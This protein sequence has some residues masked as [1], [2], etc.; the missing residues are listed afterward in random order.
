MMYCVKSIGT[1]VIVPEIV[2]MG[3]LFLTKNALDCLWS[4]VILYLIYNNMAMDC[5]L[6]LSSVVKFS[7]P[8]EIRIGSLPVIIINS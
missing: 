5:N 3:Q 7:F 8:L 2:A 6:L 4:Q 1:K